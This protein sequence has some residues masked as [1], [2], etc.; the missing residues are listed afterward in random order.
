M[1]TKTTITFFCGVSIIS[2]MDK[3]EF[4]KN[5]PA[6]AATMTQ[7][8]KIEF[9]RNGRQ[10]ANQLTQQNIQTIKPVEKETSL[11]PQTPIAETI[12]LKNDVPQQEE[13]IFQ[14]SVP[15]EVVSDN[16]ISDDSLSTESELINYAIK[17]SLDDKAPE[18]QPKQNIVNKDSVSL[19][20]IVQ[21]VENIPGIAGKNIIINY[22]VKIKQKVENSVQNIN[23]GKKNNNH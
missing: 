10:I 8:Q 13:N 17:L 23:I 18:Q 4:M 5:G 3:I 19:N 11:P 1:L 20:E 6:L 7:Q 21:K 22:N 14:E 15:E 9:M 2:A 12:P 16:G